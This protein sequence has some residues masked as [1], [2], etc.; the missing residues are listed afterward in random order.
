MTPSRAFLTSRWD[1]SLCVC[2]GIVKMS[3]QCCQPYTHA[4]HTVTCCVRYSDSDDKHVC[5]CLCLL[6]DLHPFCHC[7]RPP[8]PH[9]KVS[10]WACHL[11]LW[12]CHPAPPGYI[13]RAGEMSDLHHAMQVCL[14][15]V[16]GCPHRSRAD[17]RHTWQH[18]L[19]PPVVICNMNTNSKAPRVRPLVNT[20]YATGVILY[21]FFFK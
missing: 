5:C 18:T 8:S 11:A 7:Y 19:P 3:L 1:V 21:L 4:A 17:Y 9:R 12:Q 20:Q 14:T 15:V 13:T 16:S 6:Y 10:S 2:G